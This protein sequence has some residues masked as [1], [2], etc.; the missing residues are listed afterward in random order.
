MLVSLWT[1]DLYQP[2][3]PLKNVDFRL[4]YAGHGFPTLENGKYV[5]S[6]DTKM[7]LF[8]YVQVHKEEKTM[9]MVYFLSLFFSFLILFWYPLILIQV[10]TCFSSSEVTCFWPFLSLFIVYL[11][12]N[13]HFQSLWTFCS[14]TVPQFPFINSLRSFSTWFCC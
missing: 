2:L 14:F 13:F 12:F 1:W 5:I 10:S 3:V 11:F 4:S 6:E 7:S 9:F 8:E